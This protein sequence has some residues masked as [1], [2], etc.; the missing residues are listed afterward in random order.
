MIKVEKAMRN[1]RL[2]KSLTGLNKEE[3]ENLEPYF[4]K[5]MIEENKKKIKNN[6]ERKRK[7]GGGVKHTL[8]GVK[9]RLFYIL[10]YCKV[11]PTFD[12]AGF[13]FGV[14]KSQTNRWMH[15]LLAIIEKTLN[16]QT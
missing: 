8:E 9:E 4:E 3:F 15:S 10:F 13:V 7:E 16:S 5:I 11:Y 12:V 6:K 14:D 2:M 1:D